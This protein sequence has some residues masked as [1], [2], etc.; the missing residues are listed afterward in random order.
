MKLDDV[1]RNAEYNEQLTTDPTLSLLVGKG[2][3]NIFKLILFRVVIGHGKPG[4]HGNWSEVREIYRKILEK[5]GKL[6]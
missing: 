2:E 4:S 6:G 1:A 3:F 5:S